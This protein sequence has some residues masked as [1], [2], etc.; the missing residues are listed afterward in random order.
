MHVVRVRVW[1]DG[2]VWRATS[3]G[4]QG[5]SRMSSMVGANG[6]VFCPPLRRDSKLGKKWM[7]R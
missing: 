5:S 1:R 4:D 2:S 6:L 7:S 3:T